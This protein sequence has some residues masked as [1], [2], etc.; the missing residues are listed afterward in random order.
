MYLLC[1]FQYLF[2]ICLLSPPFWIDICWGKNISRYN[3]AFYV[4]ACNLYS[5]CCNNLV[6]MQL[7]HTAEL[8]VAIK[9]ILWKIMMTN[10]KTS[11]LERAVQV[12]LEE[13]CSVSCHSMSLYS[14]IINFNRKNMLF[15][16]CSLFILCQLHSNKLE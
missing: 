10:L 4:D 5:V 11:C 1:L 14:L 9:H 7:M 8:L 2:F 6:I 3:E 12:R 16:L 13:I 15:I